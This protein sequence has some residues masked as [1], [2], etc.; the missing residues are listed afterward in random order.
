MADEKK[1]SAREAGIAV[2]KKVEELLKSHHHV[3]WG[4][5]HGKLEREGYSK[6]SADKIAGAIKAKV[7]PAHKHEA[8]GDSGKILK[9][10]A[11]SA[12]PPPPPA[13]GGTINSQIGFPFGKDE[14]NPPDGVRKQVA[15][16]HNPH[17]QAENNN[18]ETMPGSLKLAKFLGHMEAKRKLKAGAPMDKGED[19]LS[20]DHPAPKRAARAADYKERGDMKSHEIAMEGLKEAHKD[21]A[22]A[23]K[24][25]PKPKLP[26]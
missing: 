3:G 7:H 23:I 21:K 25:Q 1:I 5:L 9:K 8:D 15:P 11:G 12:P 2:L 20:A 6:E 18:A 10:D 24:A 26:G 19:P 22:E 17:V 4:K 14:V 13:G 16:E